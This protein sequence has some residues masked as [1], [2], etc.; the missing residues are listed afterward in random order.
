MNTSAPFH[1]DHYYHVYNR[2]NNKEKLFRTAENRSYFLRQYKKYLG[3]YVDIH[4]YALMSNHFHFSIRVKS[5]QEV[6]DYIASLKEVKLTV[7]LRKYRDRIALEGK[8]RI[9]SSDTIS[10][11]IISQHRRFFISYTQSIN[12]SYGRQGNLF[13]ARFKR[14]LFDPDEKFKYMLYYLHH[15]SR[16][17]NIVT[18][19][20]KYKHTSYEFILKED[21]WLIDINE[22]KKRF[23]SLEKFEAFHQGVHFEDVFENIIIEDTPL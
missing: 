9:A 2:T 16:K 5:E 23:G 22:V 14:S 18:D 19:F 12:K 17:H 1:Y 4:A 6:H 11:V 20:K 21:D 8:D 13:N 10:S 15:N 7:P 3:P